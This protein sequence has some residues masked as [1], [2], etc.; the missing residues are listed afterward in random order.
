MSTHDE[1]LNIESFK[2]GQLYSRLDVAEVGNVTPPAQSRDWPGYVKFKNCILLFVTLN[3]K[4]FSSGTQYKDIFDDSGRLFHWESQN[5]NTVQTP[6][7]REILEGKTT[8]LFTRVVDKVKGRTQKFVYVGR[9]SCIEHTGK[10]PVKCLYNVDEYCSTPSNAVHELYHWCEDSDLAR[11]PELV[12]KR[13]QATGGQGR[14]IDPKK[15]KAIELHAMDVARKHYADLGYEVRDTSNQ[16]PYDFECENTREI[17]RVEVKG[18]TMDP[19]KVNL[20]Y[21]EVMSARE[22][23]CE[24]DLFIVYA[25]IVEKL[26]EEYSTSGGLIKRI[27]NWFPENDDLTPTAYTYSVR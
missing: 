14:L 10:K 18:T 8:I 5:G 15:K 25:I 1:S 27:N 12:S 22:D 19:S 9:L 6:F 4:N 21:N 24:T 23:I 3:K 7:V 16:K 17:R 20:T 13:H 2:V 26:D 11:K